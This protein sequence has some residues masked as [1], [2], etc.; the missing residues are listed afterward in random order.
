MWGRAFAR[1]ESVGFWERVWEGGAALKTMG[2]VAR[3]MW[4]RG[5]GR[6]S[7]RGRAWERSAMFGA[8]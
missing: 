6:R 4:R 5:R 2:R 8:R 1:R 7:C 3:R